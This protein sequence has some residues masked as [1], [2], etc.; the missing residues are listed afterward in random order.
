MT[1]Q[2]MLTKFDQID[3]ETNENVRIVF[4]GS[5]KDERGLPE[6]AGDNTSDSLVEISIVENDER[7]ISS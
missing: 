6:L 3:C 1:F 2:E 7:S 5:D 4:A